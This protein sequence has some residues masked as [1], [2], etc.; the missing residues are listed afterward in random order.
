[1]Q[2]LKNR[3]QKLTQSS[4]FQEYRE[5]FFES[6]HYMKHYHLLLLTVSGLFNL[7]IYVDLQ[8]PW[9]SKR[10]PQYLFQN[11]TVT[12]IGDREGSCDPKIDIFK[13]CNFVG[14]QP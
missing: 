13:S 1:M 6:R 4:I 5:I 7:P 10:T 12:V 3:P 2:N 11:D 14:S 9:L 8:D